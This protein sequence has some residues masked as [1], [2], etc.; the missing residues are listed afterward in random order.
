MKQS[1][2][3]SKRIQF[4]NSMADD[5]VSEERKREY[6]LGV[7]EPGEPDYGRVPAWVTYITTDEDGTCVGWELK[8][9]HLE[10]YPQHVS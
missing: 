6:L 9:Y 1:D 10:N 7:W 4:I 5:I 2:L 3:D 8:P